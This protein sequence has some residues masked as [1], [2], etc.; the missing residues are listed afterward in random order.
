VRT[1]VTF[2]GAAPTNIAG[3][4]SWRPAAGSPW[5]ASGDR[6]VFVGGAQALWQGKP[7]PAPHGGA[8]GLYVVDPSGGAMPTLIDSG[9]DRAPQWSYLDPSTAFLM[10]A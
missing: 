9:V 4:T 3:V 2:P 10:M 6:F 8:T 1:L 7:L 5:N